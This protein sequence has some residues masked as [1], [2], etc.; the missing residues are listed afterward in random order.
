VLVET[1]A[2][3]SEALPESSRRGN[4]TEKAGASASYDT[5]I[6]TARRRGLL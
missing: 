1:G 6:R 2:E 5:E 3:Q 4:S